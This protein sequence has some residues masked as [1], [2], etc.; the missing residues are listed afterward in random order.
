MVEMR[1]ISSSGRP[2]G[3]VQVPGFRQRLEIWVQEKVRAT[4]H[5][6]L[7]AQKHLEANFQ[8]DLGVISVAQLWEWHHQYIPRIKEVKVVQKVDY[9]VWWNS[10]SKHNILV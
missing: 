5:V 7:G 1:V 10:R 2:V 3:K 9:E 8:A 6:V 4:D